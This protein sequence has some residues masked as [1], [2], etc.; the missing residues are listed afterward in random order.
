MSHRNRE[1]MDDSLLF[2]FDI[3]SAVLQPGIFRLRTR[4]V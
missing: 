3:S 1:G 2:F 4:K